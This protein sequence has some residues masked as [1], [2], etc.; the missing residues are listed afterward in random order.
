MLTHLHT[1]ISNMKAMLNATDE[2][3]DIGFAEEIGLTGVGLLLH[4]FGASQ[5]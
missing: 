1:A 4:D 2:I 5:G 3:L